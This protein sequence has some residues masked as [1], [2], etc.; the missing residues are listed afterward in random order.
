ATAAK[1]RDEAAQAGKDLDELVKKLSA[2]RDALE[3]PT[4]E[5][6]RNYTAAVH[7]AEKAA[8]AGMDARTTGDLSAASFK[9]SLGDV[10]AT[11]ARSLAA[12]SALM[13]MIVDAKP[14]LPTHDA[15][16]AKAKAVADELE[17]TTKDAQHAYKD[18]KDL[19]E[20]AGGGPAVTDHTK[21][22]VEALKALAGASEEPAPAEAGKPPASDKKTMTPAQPGTGAA[23]PAAPAP[24]ASDNAG[25]GEHAPAPAPAP[26]TPAPKPA[27]PGD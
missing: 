23:S 17:Q 20:K 25:P 26:T 15:M 22:I 3:H 13:Q 5:A 27:Q 9:A 18:A 12:Y 2:A 1:A 8:R 6:T 16:Q 14:A 24:K 21:H 10:L 7:D 19:F 4:Q 11:K